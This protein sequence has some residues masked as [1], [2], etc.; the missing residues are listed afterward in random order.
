LLSEFTKHVG[1]QEYLLQQYRL[2]SEQIAKDILS[3][4]QDENWL[5]VKQKI[6]Q[7]KAV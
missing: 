5:L 3:M 1:N 4:F 6:M 7:K 2:T